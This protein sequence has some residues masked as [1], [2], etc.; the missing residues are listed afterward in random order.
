MK[1]TIGIRR[2][3]RFSRESVRALARRY[4]VSP[5]TVQKWKHRS[6][7]DDLP[8]GPK[9]GHGKAVPQIIER[10][11]IMFRRQTL[12]P[13][14]DCYYALQLNMLGISR[15]TL[16]RYFKRR[17]LGSLRNLEGDKSLKAL[18]R[19]SIGH[20][21]IDVNEIRL[22]D[23]IAF[24]FIAFDR[25][26]KF[27]FWQA[28][29]RDTAIDATEFLES[30]LE[31]LPFT[32]TIRT[33]RRECFTADC[34]GASDAVDS[35]PGFFPEMCRVRGIRHEIIEPLAVLH[36]PE[37]AT[38]AAA[39]SFEFETESELRTVLDRQMRL[40]NSRCRLK[41]LGGK[42]PA[43]FIAYSNSTKCDD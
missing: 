13:L 7:D 35:R 29:S 9:R 15:T 3:L 19:A 32:H 27:A 14:D 42:T 40:F 5:T 26:S 11:L 12:L 16:Y 22:R 2:Q 43:Q 23:G 41:V 17:G 37:S 18:R 8:S 30:L 36:V 28:R 31:V 34:V 21:H 24:A 20:V 1:T 38:D 25:V 39:S 4:H 6:F 33:D 10:S